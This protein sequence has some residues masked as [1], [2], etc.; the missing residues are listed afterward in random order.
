MRG[1]LGLTPAERK[2]TGN[3]GKRKAKAREVFFSVPQGCPPPPPELCEAAQRIWAEQI[4]DVV[5]M[6]ML[7]RQGY[8][9]F[10]MY[11]DA[12]ARYWKYTDKLSKGETYKT[13]TGFFRK[14]PEV[15]LRD[16]AFND[17]AKLAEQL[18]LTP[19]SWI[20]AASARQSR[21]LDVFAKQLDL[22]GEAGHTAPASPEAAATEID[23]FDRFKDDR[24]VH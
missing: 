20:A 3:A 19:K 4:G 9:V 24:S 22:F 8:Q 12:L 17:V 6:V 16:R 5:K 14:K 21:E 13:D 1:R 11:C 7:Q 2:L 18:T 15:E 10:A 23:D